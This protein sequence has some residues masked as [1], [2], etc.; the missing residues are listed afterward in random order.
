MMAWTVMYDVMQWVDANGDPA[1]GYVLKAYLPGTT[2][3]TNIAIDKNGGSPQATITLNA[4]GKP[5]VSGN[6]VVP[7]IDREYKWAI[8][9]NAT[10][11][12]ANSNPYAG[13]YDNVPQSLRADDPSVT[14]S[15]YE[16]DTT[17]LMAA[18]TVKDYA[19]GDVVRTKEF[20]TG[21]GGGGVY[22]VVLTT[23]VT[24]NAYNIIQGA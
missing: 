2:T 10:D 4:E 15:S 24:P 22:D 21:N 17:A 18:N 8:F 3:A 5:E 1:S 9:Q 16:E 7:F 19:A 11:A 13:F 20:S 23:S 12:A 14:G 6:E